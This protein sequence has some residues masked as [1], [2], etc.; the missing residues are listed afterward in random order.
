MTYSLLIV[1]IPFFSLSNKMK[2]LKKP[3]KI[4]SLSILEHANIQNLLILLHVLPEMGTCEYVSKCTMSVS[5]SDG[6]NGA[7]WGI[8]PRIFSL[9]LVTLSRFSRTY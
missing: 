8:D 5:L 6:L 1:L 2:P 3:H 7:G 4:P 9:T